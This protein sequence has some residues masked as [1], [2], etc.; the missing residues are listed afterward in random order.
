MEKIGKIIKITFD[1]GLE[2]DY[3]GYMNMANR[4]KVIYIEPNSLKTFALNISNVTGATPNTLK[5]SIIE[6]DRLL[7]LG[8]II[9][10]NGKIR[11]VL[12]PVKGLK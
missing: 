12:E 7:D 9:E 2:Y 10:E 8:I 6:K 1:D 5:K 11:R 3:L 4:Y